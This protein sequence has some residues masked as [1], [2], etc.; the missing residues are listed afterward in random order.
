MA[1]NPVIFE[2]IHRVK[3]SDLDPYNHLRT[4]AYAGYFVD[5][6]MEGLR[7]RIGW[8]LQTLAELPFMVWVKRLEIEFLKPAFGDQEITITSF[9]REFRES[10]ADIECR[11]ADAGGKELSRCRMIVTCVDKATQRPM[12]WPVE[13]AALFYQ[14]PTG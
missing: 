8:D 3:F 5:H 14:E 9:V 13:A 11:M 10:D 12:T 4:A 2:T 6:R 1:K 7:G